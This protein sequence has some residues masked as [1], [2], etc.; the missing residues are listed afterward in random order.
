MQ[1]FFDLGL[2]GAI[3][4]FDKQK[5]VKVIK[6]QLNNKAKK[7]CQEKILQF[8]HLVKNL[9]SQPS[10][11]KKIGCHKPFGTNRNTIINLALMSCVLIIFFAQSEFV[12]INE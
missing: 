2:K 4:I 7:S 12:F 9:F 1:I 8:H 3:S 5:F 10:K 6:Y 11:I